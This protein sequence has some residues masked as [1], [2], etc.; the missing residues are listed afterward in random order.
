MFRAL[1]LQAML[2]LLAAVCVL[3]ALGIIYLDGLSA[4]DVARAQAQNEATRLAENIAAIQDRTITATRQMLFTLSILPEV[5]ALNREACSELF[6]QILKTNPI[7]TNI[8]VTDPAGLV[9]AAAVPHQAVTLADRKHFKDAARTKRFVPGEFIVSRTTGVPSFPLAYPVLDRDGTIL[10]MVMVALEL[11]RLG[12]FFV[13]ERL[14]DGSFLGIADYQGRRLFR[15]STDIENMGKPISREVWDAARNDPS[16]QGIFVGRGS[17]GVLRLTAFSKLRLNRD[18]EPY[19]TFFV[20]IPEATITA[21]TRSITIRGGLL[22][23]MAGAMAMGLAWVTAQSLIRPKIMKLVRT[24]ER[25]SAGDFSR[26]TGLD[27]HGGEL[28]MVAAALDRLGRERQQT[29]AMLRQATLLAEEASRAKSEF[30]ANMSHEIRTPLNGIMGMLQLLETTD[31]NEEQAEYSMLAFQATKR[32]NR[33]LSDILDISRIEAG[34]MKIMA[35]PFAL[36]ESVRQSVEMLRPV[37]MQSG[38]RLQCHID[39]AV[40]REARG[41]SV[42]LQQILINLIGNALKFTTEGS[43]DLEVHPLQPR[44]EDQIRIFFSITDT[45]CGISDDN[46]GRLFQPFSQVDQGYA[47]SHQGAGLG[48]SICKR[49]I[50]FMDGSITVESESDVGTTFSFCVTLG[51]HGN[52]ATGHSEQAGHEAGHHP[53]RLLLAEDDDMSLMVGKQLLEKNGYVV[54]TARDGREVLQILK[55]EDFDAVLMDIQMPVMDGMEAMTRIRQGEAGA[56][57]ANIP[58]IALTAYAMAGDRE[59]LL[60]AGMNGYVAKPVAIQELRAAIDAALDG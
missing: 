47:R 9:V 30:L 14:P 4:R 26:P 5:R 38:V 42:R 58:I 31:Q 54:S 15:T 29:E 23:L 43:V 46:L 36:W 56:A 49:L 1:S 11:E 19:M 35:E 28:E 3:P 60:A 53:S 8:L 17:D 32:L 39:P 44:R 22:T 10:G 7:Y 37:A 55:R 48:L 21:G 50:E 52:D 12:E 16:D 24:A 45:G 59:K 6:H 20:A 40:P 57:K 2:Y 34:K 41:D 18:S 25:F 51:R 33:L 13:S 27:H